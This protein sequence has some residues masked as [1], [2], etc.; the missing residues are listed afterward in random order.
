MKPTRGKT[1]HKYSKLVQ[2][3][4]EKG[5]PPGN[6]FNDTGKG[7][8]FRLTSLKLSDIEGLCQLSGGTIETL[9]IS[10]LKGI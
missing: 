8:T 5:F 7:S 10:G 4:S 1:F 9:G 6:L 3:E 2:Q